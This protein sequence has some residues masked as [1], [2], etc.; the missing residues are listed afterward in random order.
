MDMAYQ[1]LHRALVAD[2]DLEE[3]RACWNCFPVSGGEIIHNCDRM[4]PAQQFSATN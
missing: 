1:G 2:I 4:P 3:C